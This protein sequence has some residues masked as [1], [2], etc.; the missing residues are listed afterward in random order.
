M[1]EESTSALDAYFLYRPMLE[2]RVIDI[3]LGLGL[4]LPR[5]NS[6]VSFRNCTRI[7]RAFRKAKWQDE[8]SC[9]GLWNVNVEPHGT[10]RLQDKQQQQQQQ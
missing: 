6:L 2:R 8:C 10:K 7:A 3:L 1:E 5:K 4:G 9:W